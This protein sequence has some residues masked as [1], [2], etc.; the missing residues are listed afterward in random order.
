MEDFLKLA[1][2]YGLGMFLAVGIAVVFF[3]H[4]RDKDRQSVAR[5]ERLMRFMEEHSLVTQKIVED[6]IK[7]QDIIAKYQREEHSAMLGTLGLIKDS[8]NSL[9]I[10]IIKEGKYG[11]Q[12]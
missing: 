12:S 2:N 1:V 3:L 4:L 7:N 10:N 8:L 9:N 5:E 11:H 6:N